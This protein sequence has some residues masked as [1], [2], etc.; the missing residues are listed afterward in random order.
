MVEDGGG[1]EEVGASLV[2]AELRVPV[3]VE[4]VVVETAAEG[5]GS[6]FASSFG[7]F[8]V[9]YTTMRSAA[10]QKKPTV[11]TMS[12]VLERCCGGAVATGI[13]Y[14]DD[15]ACGGGCDCIIGYGDE[16]CSSPP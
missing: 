8:F 13:E 11:M 4:G 15:G 6:S 2:G 9:P 14:I 1:G 3:V 12:S 10:R 16:P 7:V 5:F